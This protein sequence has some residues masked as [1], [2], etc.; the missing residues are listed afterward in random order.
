[1][2]TPVAASG[3]DDSEAAYWLQMARRILSGE[4]APQDARAALNADEP[5]RAGARSKRPT[6]TQH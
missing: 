5:G 4:I 6:P 1:M 3:D 2:T